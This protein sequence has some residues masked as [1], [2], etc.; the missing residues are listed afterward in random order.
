MAK[1]YSE[2]G[3]PED[4]IE[5]VKAEEAIANLK[6]LNAGIKG[7]HEKIYYQSYDNNAHN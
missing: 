1:C 2:F 4:H 6:S 5:E 3:K 7:F